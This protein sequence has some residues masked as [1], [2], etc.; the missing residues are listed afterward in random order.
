VVPGD[1]ASVAFTTE[2]GIGVYLVQRGETLCVVLCGG[3]KSIQQKDSERT[4]QLAR[5]LED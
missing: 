2:L 5:E 4:K 1:I 3:N